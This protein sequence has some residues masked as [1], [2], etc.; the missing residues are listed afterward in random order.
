[1]SDDLAD[2]R[3][4]RRIAALLPGLRFVQ[5]TQGTYTPTYLGTTP[6][7][8]TYS[9]QQG[10]WTRWGNLVFVTGT[11]VWTAATG[12]G[13]AQISLPFAAAATANQN[14]SGSVRN[15][16]VTFANSTPQI[17]LASAGS[18]F[19]LQSP[20]TNAASTNVAIEAAGNIVF[21]LLYFVE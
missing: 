9:T 21:S 5:Q 14:Y 18:V 11:I 20:L 7:V 16:T 17:L 15:T 12:T 6:G 3:L 8:T 13:N 1:M 4:A 2:Q 19:L 10:G